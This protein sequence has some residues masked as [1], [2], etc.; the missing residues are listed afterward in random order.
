MSAFSPMVPSVMLG[1]FSR[2]N[3]E[4]IIPIAQ[5]R[6]MILKQSGWIREVTIQNVLF[7]FLSVV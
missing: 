4:R 1:T 3:V 6:V 7:V 2:A 5:R